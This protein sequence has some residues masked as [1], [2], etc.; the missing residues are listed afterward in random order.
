MLHTGRIF[1]GICFSA[2]LGS[3]PE[4]LQCMR[5]RHDIIHS[6]IL[7][8]TIRHQQKAPKVLLS[9]FRIRSEVIQFTERVYPLSQVGI[10]MNH[11]LK[12]KKP[13]NRLISVA[14]NVEIDNG[15]HPTELSSTDRAPTRPHQQP[16][17]LDFATFSLTVGVTVCNK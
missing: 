4:L 14:A 5:R 6:I 17:D 16:K 9:L 7:R 12:Q 8:L 11:V 10:D 3:S 1:P 15:R 2:H 13:T